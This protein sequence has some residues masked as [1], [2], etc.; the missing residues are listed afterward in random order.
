[1][2]YQKDEET[3]RLLALVSDFFKELWKIGKRE[4][5]Q[6]DLRFSQYIAL[7]C[8]EEEPGITMG[9]LARRI[10]TTGPAVT[11][12]VDNIIKKKCMER[13]SDPHDRHDVHI[14]IS[15]NGRTVLKKIEGERN[16]LFSSLLSGLTRKQ[17]KALEKILTALFETLKNR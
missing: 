6:Q 16:Q 7:R 11:A 1:M 13:Y 14:C 5:E 2:K 10:G 9:E 12:I 8:M 17:A 4:L 15:D 3:A